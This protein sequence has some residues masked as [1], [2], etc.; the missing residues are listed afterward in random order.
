MLTMSPAELFKLSCLDEDNQV[1]YA[2]MSQVIDHSPKHGPRKFAKADKDKS[3]SLNRKEYEASLKKVKWWR[4]SRKTPKAMF[5]PSDIDN[6]GVLSK[7]EFTILL[8]KEADLDTFFKRADKNSSG[9][10]GLN[11]VTIH[12]K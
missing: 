5:K 8:G 7:K 2:E 12:I 3:G 1:S 4:L 10:L 6:N 9:D 11:E